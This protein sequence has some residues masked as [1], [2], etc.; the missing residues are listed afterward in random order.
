MIPISRLRQVVN[1][2]DGTAASPSI[3]FSNDLDTGMYRVTENT[4][5]IAT[6][7][8]ER[9]RVENN[10]V[11]PIDISGLV[12]QK[13]YYLRLYGTPS[14]YLVSPNFVYT[15]VGIPFSSAGTGYYYLAFPSHA[16]LN[17]TPIVQNT[18]QYKVPVAGIYMVVYSLG[19]F[20]Y[21]GTI[22][23]FI[24]KN[25]GNNNTFPHSDLNSGDGDGPLAY[26][27]NTSTLTAVTTLTTA[28]YICVGFYTSGANVTMS[29][30]CSLTLTLLQ[31]T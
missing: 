29:T 28:D 26:A 2:D 13:K 16:H 8:T 17:F 20:G 31:P 30:R 11:V 12:R 22:E 4:V 5:A 15:Q 18:V 23:N 24:S 1:A 21:T 6:N 10:A 7:G 3:S 27:Q 25:K 19:V 9:M 14:V